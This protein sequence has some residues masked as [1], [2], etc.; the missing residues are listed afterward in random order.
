MSRTLPVRP[1]LEHLKNQARSRL[2]ELQR[3]DPSAQLSDALHAT[4]R[5]YG[6]SSWPVLKEHVESMPAGLDESP[7]AGVWRADL[8]NSPEPVLRLCDAAAL[9]FAID[10]DRVTLSDTVQEQSGAETRHTHTL[11]VGGPPQQVEHG[12]VMAAAWQGDRVLTVSVA[13]DGAH[14][15]HVSYAVSGDG[16]TLTLTAAAAAHAGY[17]AVEQTIRFN[18]AADPR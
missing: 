12:Y 17:P 3:H 8:D 1:N 13:R 16:R 4:A 15:M 14:V 2:S 10:G 5:E 18:R 6:F 9:E 11:R 7:F